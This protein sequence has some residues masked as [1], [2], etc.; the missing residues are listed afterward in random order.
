MVYTAMGLIQILYVALNSF[1][2]VLMIKGRKLLASCISTIEIFIYV[3]G[4]ALVL[5]H[6]ETP[7]GIIVYS[8][9]YGAGIMVG[10]YIEQK[11]AIGYITLH[12]ISEKEM[13]MAEALREK[14]YGVTTWIGNG[15]SGPRMV[16]MILA[17]RKEYHHL[18]TVIQEVDPKAFIVAYEPR[19]FVGG[20]WTK[21]LASR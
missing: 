19:H 20:F 7:L 14:G 4:L 2:L 1:R 18:E 3:T 6:L 12:V 15:A 11:I 9:S 16:Y 17:K 8:A 5:N 10:I 21:K 13:G